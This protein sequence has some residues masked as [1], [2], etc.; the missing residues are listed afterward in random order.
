MKIGIVGSE[1][2]VGSAM[3]ALFSNAICY[4]LKIGTKDEINQCH[5]VFVCVPTPSRRR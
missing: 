5:T 3:K 2:H 1:G 4:D